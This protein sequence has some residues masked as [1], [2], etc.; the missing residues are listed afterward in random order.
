[1][2]I[3]GPTVQKIYSAHVTLFENWVLQELCSAGKVCKGVQYS[4]ILDIVLMV[5]VFCFSLFYWNRQC[6]KTIESSILHGRWV[7]FYI[8]PSV[9]EKRM[10]LQRRICTLRMISVP[11]VTL[12][13]PHTHTHTHRQGAT[14][15]I[16][17]A[18]CFAL[19]LL[20]L[21]LPAAGCAAR[22]RMGQAR[23]LCIAY[24]RKNSIWLLH[25]Y[26]GEEWPRS[27][28][29]VA[30]S[31]QPGQCMAIEFRLLLLA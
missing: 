6:H 2:Y 15:N 21:F 14:A 30:R 27:Q 26:V 28:Q 5:F 18:K 3:Y 29:P 17:L 13:V 31:Q 7:L 19:P 24:V 4:S 23:G 9:R 22:I 11:V 1:M 12:L 10:R 20:A 16:Y 25:V 8:T